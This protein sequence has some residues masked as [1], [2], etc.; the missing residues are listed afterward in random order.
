MKEATLK[1]EQGRK[2]RGR[3]KASGSDRGEDRSCLWE[4]LLAGRR[5]ELIAGVERVLHLPLGHSNRRV[6]LGK[7]ALARSPEIPSLI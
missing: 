2:L 4:A 3:K 1:R 5:Q 6:Y 7:K